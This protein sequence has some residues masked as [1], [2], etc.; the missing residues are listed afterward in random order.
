MKK[1]LLLSSIVLLFF[2]CNNKSVQIVDCEKFKTSQCS[3]PVETFNFTCANVYNDRLYYSDRAS[4]GKLLISYDFS[5]NKLDTIAQENEIEDICILNDTTIFYADYSTIGLY[6]F[7]NKVNG[8]CDLLKDIT[9]RF[10]HPFWGH[11]YYFNPVITH[12][13]ILQSESEGVV[14]CFS[15]E[16]S[17]NKFRRL[18]KDNIPLYMHFKRKDSANWD[19]SF[20]GTYPSKND[21]EN[22]YE[23][24]FLNCFYNPEK[25]C[26]VCHTR[27]DANVVLCDSL[28]KPVKEIEFSSQKFNTPQPYPITDLHS[29]Q[30]SSNYFWSNT[31]YGIIGYDKYRKVYLRVVLL[32]RQ[33]DADAMLKENIMDFVIIVAD[34]D[35]NIKYEVF[36]DGEKYV[37]P[38]YKFLINEK[39]LLVF[40]KNNKSRE[41]S[42]TA[43]WFVFE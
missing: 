20:F 37:Q 28:G 27:L 26:F 3:F 7:L 33:P 8:E 34:E 1:C 36:F 31:T 43:S 40:E 5:T 15:T 6:V 23:G 35:F 18:A 9:K 17:D 2:A 13:L 12:P 38:Y 32:P 22:Y 24:N 41:H 25:H 30:A 42:Y 21:N 4:D 10:A 19:V 14:F 39:G 16:E 11:D 29:M